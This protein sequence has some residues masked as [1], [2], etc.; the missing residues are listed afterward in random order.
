MKK[1]LSIIFVLMIY[2][3]VINAQDSLAQSLNPKPFL[4]KDFIASKIWI[5][6][7]KPV[8]TFPF[9]QPQKVNKKSLLWYG[10]LTL[11]AG[12]GVHIYQSNAWWRNQNSH[13][14]FENDNKYALQI[15]KY[16][17]YYGAYLLGHV[18]SSTLEASNVDLE[19]SYLYGSLMSFLFQMYVEI[20]DG[21]GPN[22][23]FSPGDAL[24]DLLG[25]TYFL[26]QYYFPIMH[27]FQPR[28]SY[29]PTEKV[30]SGKTNAI[31]IDDY[32]GQTF[33]MSIRM[34]NLLPSELSKYWPTFLML[35]VGTDARNLD[36]HGGG[37]REYFISFDI[38]YDVLPLHG[39]FGQWVKNTLGLFHFPMPGIRISPGFAGFAIIY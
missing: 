15:D 37:E 5:N 39:E 33:W 36:G 14:H 32:E 35:S 19:K 26:S 4:Q 9:M 25:S 3:N 11:A 2:F 13:F 31:I 6:S 21:F 23:G 20:E 1:A 34:K 16:G 29:W 17:H 7:I 24:A 38:D 28:L 27:N 12:I 10:G 8:K 30:L 18:F 22:W